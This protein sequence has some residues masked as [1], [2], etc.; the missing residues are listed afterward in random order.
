M[1]EKYE[2][3]HM[4]LLFYVFVIVFIVIF[5]DSTPVI[6]YILIRLLSHWSYISKPIDIGTNGHWV[7]ASTVTLCICTI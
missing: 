5:Q 6:G 2:K 1:D 4:K 7:L 3:H